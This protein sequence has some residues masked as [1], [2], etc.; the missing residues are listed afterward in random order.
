[1]VKNGLKTK[2]GIPGQA[3]F[4]LIELL[5]AVSIFT[6]AL[7]VATDLF[8][9]ITQS[10]RYTI[11]AINIEENMR[12]A[13]EIISKEI[14]N[15]QSP[16]GSCINGNPGDDD[17][18]YSALKS[19]GNPV[20]SIYK[21]QGAGQGLAFRNKYGQCTYYY[22]DN[23]RLMI[24]RDGTVYPITPL[25]IKINNLSFYVIGPSNDPGYNNE[26]WTATIYL[27]AEV[28]QKANE[29][30]S[31]DIQTTVTSRYYESL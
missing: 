14:R 22:L 10:Q 23:G 21:G 17:N 5:V 12:Y 13:L 9:R 31:L 28:V 1:M 7:L 16:V 2:F 30:Q 27:Q 15:A 3:G 8:Q 24:S 19:N 4:T 29:K 11:A 18:T 6:F 26:K 25:N 20:G